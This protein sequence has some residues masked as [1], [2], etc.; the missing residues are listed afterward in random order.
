MLNWGDDK[1]DQPEE[2]IFASGFF[3]WARMVEERP[4][5]PLNESVYTEKECNAFWLKGDLN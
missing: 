3:G 2:L 1:E 5:E 4:S